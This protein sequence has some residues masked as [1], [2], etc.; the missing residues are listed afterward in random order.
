[1]SRNCVLTAVVLGT[2][3]IASTRSSGDETPR[4]DREI[5]GRPELQTAD[6]LAEDAAAAT[7]AVERL[8]KAGPA[9]LAALL[10]AHRDLL[11]GPLEIR[12]RTADPRWPRLMAALDAVGA[13]RNCYTSRL[14]WHTDLSA[15]VDAARREAK[16]I[17][18][19]RL[20]GK[21]TDEFSCANSRYFRTSLYANHEIG[22]YLR[23]HFILHWQTVRPVPHVTIDF[24]D[25]RKLQRTLTGNSI[26]W[27]LDSNGKPFDA[28][29]GL[30][31]PQ[32]F[33]RELKLIEVG[34]QSA[35]RLDDAR[36]NASFVVYHRNRL[37]T[38]GQGWGRDLAEL[39]IELPAQV[40]PKSAA[41]REAGAKQAEAGAVAAGVRAASKGVVEFPMLRALAFSMGRYRQVTTDEVWQK[42]GALHQADAILDQA[43]VKLIERENPDLGETDP[44]T[45]NRLSR[46]ESLAAMVQAFEKSM[47]IDSV[48]NEYE[49]RRQLHEWFVA[50]AVRDLEPLNERVYAELFL[51][52]RA[53]PWLG[54]V[55][56]ESYTGLERGG[57]RE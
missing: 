28:L 7:A 55:Q 10:E 23:E 30:Y 34:I 51:T 3:F 29:P 20:L 4:A 31:G 56:P 54:L 53:D 45:G 46:R 27:V 52:P 22:D 42:L 6:V 57:R 37:Q 19:L 2:L 32:A 5:A 24:G 21:L 14:Y 18:S 12:D 9:G 33:L 15:A 11:D 44:A 8:R 50:G 16:P 17:L 36:R 39:K 40:G 41:V 26:H 47:A 48:R 49:L 38:I 43:S 13:Q 35:A 25:G 1:M